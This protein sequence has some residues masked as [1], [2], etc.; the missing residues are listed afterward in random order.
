MGVLIKAEEKLQEVSRIQCGLQNGRVCTQSPS[1]CHGLGKGRQL[2][3]V[4]VQGLSASIFGS[5]NYILPAAAGANDLWICLFPWRMLTRRTFCLFSLSQRNCL[6]DCEILL[7]GIQGEILMMTRKI[8]LLMH[9]RLEKHL[10]RE[11]HTRRDLHSV[12]LVWSVF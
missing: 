11:P 3:A 12:H 7:F 9:V 8:F 2:I 1:D 4:F 10:I 6:H 5:E